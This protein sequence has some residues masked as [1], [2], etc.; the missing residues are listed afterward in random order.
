MPEQPDHTRY[1]SDLRAETVAYRDAVE[2]WET[3][4]DRWQKMIVAAI[5]EGGLMIKDVAALVGVSTSRVHAIIA[6]V[7]SRPQT[8]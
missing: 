5:D 3:R 6:H 4:R 2:V 7:A 1:V 8:A